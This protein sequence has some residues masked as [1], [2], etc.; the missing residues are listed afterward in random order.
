MRYSCT[1]CGSVAF[2]IWTPPP[3]TRLGDRF[4]YVVCDKCGKLFRF[5][6]KAV[7]VVGDS[8]FV[9]EIGELIPVRHS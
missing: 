4:T 2:N 3:H 5:Q 6:A 1:D 9:S 7:C 8:S